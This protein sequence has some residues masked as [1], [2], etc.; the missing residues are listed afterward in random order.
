MTLSLLRKWSNLSRWGNSLLK[1]ILINYHTLKVPRYNSKRYQ[2]TLTSVRNAKEK[3]KENFFCLDKNLGKIVCGLERA[4]KSWD[5]NMRKTSSCLSNRSTSG[6]GI[7]PGREIGKL[8]VSLTNLTNNHKMKK[9]LS[10]SKMNLVVTLLGWESKEKKNR[11]MPM[12]S[13]TYVSF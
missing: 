5:N 13:K 9:W 3:L 7:K 2:V 4:S 11:M 1:M 10:V 6:G 12:L 8:L